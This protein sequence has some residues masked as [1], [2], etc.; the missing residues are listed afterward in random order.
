MKEF[1]V[2]LLQCGHEH[3][4]HYIVNKAKISSKITDK[5]SQSALCIKKC[6]E[7]MFER[8]SLQ[9]ADALG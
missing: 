2:R 3:Y 4:V 6:L 9:L 5:H 8:C 1:I 7:F